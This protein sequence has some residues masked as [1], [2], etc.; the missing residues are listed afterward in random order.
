MDVES[1]ICANVAWQ[2]LPDEVRMM[3]GNSTKEYDK[4][5]VEYSVKNQLRHKGNLVRHIK[6]DAEAYYD[7]VIK[8]SASHLM[9]F[10]Y[11]LSDLV[12]RELRVTPFNYYVQI[13]IEMINAEKSYDSL[14]NFTAADAMRLLGV[15]RNQYIDLMNQNRSNRRLFRRAK[16][17]REMLPGQP[18]PQ[19]M[20]PWWTVSTGSILE[21]DI[22]MLNAEEKATIDILLD[23][24]PAITGAIPAGIIDHRVVQSLFTK[25]L[26]YFDVPVR[27]DD[28]IFVGPLDGFVMNRVLGDYFET[29]LYK[30]FVTIDG[31][32]TVAEIADMLHID[33]QLAKNA[34]AVFCR[35]GFAKKRVTGMEGERL[36]P[37]WST[38][39]S[40][41]ATPT[42]SL[43]QLQ[44]LSPT[45]IL[46]TGMGGGDASGPASPTG[47]HSVAADLS[48]AFLDVDNDE[49]DETS[50][51]NGDEAGGITTSSISSAP[52]TSDVSSSG[53]CAFLFDANLTAFL[54]MGNLS[55]SLK[56][57]AV[58][59]FEVGKLTDEQLRDFMEQLEKVNRFAEGE[60]QRFSEHA[61]TLLHTLK[62][63]RNGREL[64]LIR[65]ESLLS[66]DAQSR[67]RVL[68]K[69]YSTIIA[70]A[71]L[72]VDACALPLSSL[73]ILGPPIPESCSPWC[74]L[75]LYAAAKSGL[76][77]FFVPKGTRLPF[78]PRLL[79]GARRLLVT[80]LNQAEPQLLPASA[81]L[82]AVNELLM[83]TA[84]LVQEFTGGA[85][86]DDA[87]VHVPFPFAAGELE[88]PDSLANHPSVAALRER[89]GLGSLAGY[90]VLVRQ[91]PKSILDALD[92]DEGSQSP[93]AAA[94]ALAFGSPKKKKESGE[95]GGE[96]GVESP[97]LLPPSSSHS[98]F[99]LLDVVFG[100]PLF[101][102]HL[103]AVICDRIRRE[104]VLSIENRVNIQ[105][106]NKTLVDLTQ[107]MLTKHN[108]GVIATAPYSDRV[109]VVPPVRPIGFCPDK[110]IVPYSPTE[111]PI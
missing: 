1:C 64:D 16:S 51:A 111:D 85:T 52:L 31:M 23:T 32:T 76:K 102:E 97:F 103:N 57:H 93:Y 68:L 98:D 106:A 42:G 109:E 101:D 33:V 82:A 10:P 100:I 56:S 77:S 29:L 83:T 108:F 94:A 3:L 30:I 26:V 28:Y 34:M 27:D 87:L 21:T 45:S 71:P 96:G 37:S 43:Q 38:L 69:S 92:D 24:S 47:S 60:A 44:P 55:A 53:R 105:F 18:V 70:M 49:D 5:I 19:A 63:L 35:L 8:Y 84:V 78:F 72:L 41:A 81:A 90:V 12:I 88:N 66:L 73:P 11:H 59:L 61:M 86:L 25:G 22:K 80:S 2:Q 110:G 14:P 95:G 13:I 54:M 67:A 39:P 48:E 75:A 104:E 79:S 9:L 62:S 15:G 20:E 65:G 107:E 46:A 89:I 74:R 99:V 91:Q 50:G 40:G 4:L 7:Q 36:H 58:T 17:L 6:K